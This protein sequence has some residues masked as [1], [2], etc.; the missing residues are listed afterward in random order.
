MDIIR[1]N[2]L[3]IK[4]VGPL[5]ITDHYNRYSNE[6]KK[7]IYNENVMMTFYRSIY[8]YH[9]VVRKILKNMVGFLQQLFITI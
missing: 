3:K 6:L 1:E 8:P 5:L 2:L 4:P 9:N 7:D